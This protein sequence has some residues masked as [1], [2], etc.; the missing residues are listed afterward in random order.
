MS[1]NI[2]NGGS[3]GGGGFLKP[4]EFTSAHL[5]IFEPKK[6]VQSRF[7][8]ERTGQ[9]KFEAAGDYTF[10]LSQSELDAG[11]PSDIREDALFSS[12]ILAKVLIE[13]IGNVMVGTLEK[14]QG[15]G[16]KQ[17]YWKVQPTSQANVDKAVAY[18]EQREAEK[19][20]ARED[21][22][23]FLKSADDG[24]TPPF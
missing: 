4:E 2:V 8:D 15:K 24:S 9:P 23:A 16:G 7:N 14:T 3:T 20:K 21:L 5:G 17:G 1:I 19:A 13:N 18:L 12:G 6:A 11:K 22:P 10:F